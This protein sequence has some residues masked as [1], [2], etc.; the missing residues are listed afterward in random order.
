MNR[1]FFLKLFG[2]GVATVAGANLD[3]NKPEVKAVATPPDHIQRRVT[4]TIRETYDD[5]GSRFPPMRTDGVEKKA[6]LRY[7]RKD[8][9]RVQGP[10]PL[11]SPIRDDFGTTVSF[12]GIAFVDEVV[13]QRDLRT[14]VTNV[15]L[16]L[17]I[18]PS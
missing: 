18:Y 1:R 6:S 2:A 8:G 15:D 13:R 7:W 14:G 16:T 5:D 12:D 17:S 9:F 3:L 10:T 11:T 4:G